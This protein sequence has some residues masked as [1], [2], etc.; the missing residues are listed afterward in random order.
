[1][2][3]PVEEC[4]ARQKDRPV[5]FYQLWGYYRLQRHMIEDGQDLVADS[6]GTKQ[7]E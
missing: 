2:L 5:K 7:Q 1:M 6:R 3:Y 4:E